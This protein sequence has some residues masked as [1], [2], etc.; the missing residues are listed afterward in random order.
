[1]STTEYS[2]L[3]ER[4]LSLQ[5]AAA[6]GFTRVDRELG[7]VR[8]EA[9]SLRGEMNRRFEL[10]DK[11]FDLIDDRFHEVNTR[12]DRLEALIATLKPQRKRSQDRD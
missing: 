9:G 6:D 2:D 8:V 11:R 7:P 3:M 4:I 1:M 5:S 12:F 10:V